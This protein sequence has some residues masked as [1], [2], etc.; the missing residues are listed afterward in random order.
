MPQRCIRLEIANLR[1]Q[2]RNRKE[3]R[4]FGGFWPL[5]SDAA[6]EART[7]RVSSTLLMPL[8]SSFSPFLV[9]AFGACALTRQCN[10]Q[11]FQKHGRSTTTT[12][13]IAEIGPAFNRLFET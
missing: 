3:M 7:S 9:A 6:M 5:V 1:F 2:G 13:M 8:P 4:A 10:H 11:A 12:D